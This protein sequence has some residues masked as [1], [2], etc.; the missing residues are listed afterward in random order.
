MTEAFSQNV[1]KV[2]RAYV[3]I[4]ELYFPINLVPE[5]ESLHQLI[6]QALHLPCFK[7]GGGAPSGLAIAASSGRDS[8]WRCSFQISET[9]PSFT[10]MSLLTAKEL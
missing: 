1:G 3:G 2:S 9:I 4:R 7:C 8:T 5:T 10:A 6:L